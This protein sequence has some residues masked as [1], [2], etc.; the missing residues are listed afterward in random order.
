[1][2][3]IPFPSVPNVPGVPALLRSATVPTKGQLFNG[4]LGSVAEYFFGKNI[5]GVYDDKGNLAL[6][7]DSFLSLDYQNGSRI[8][9]AP[10]EKGTFSSYN[11]VANPY[12]CSVILAIGADKAARTKFLSKLE[13][14]GDSTKLYTVVTPERT[15]TSATLESYTYKRESTNG[16]TLIKAQLNFVQIR[17]GA[18]TTTTQTQDP[19]GAA[20]ESGG[21]IQPNEPTDDEIALAEEAE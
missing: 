13:E 18:L 5:W 8:S 16:V 3:L 4:L 12:D 15:Y 9:N 17:N 2:S 11:K 10:Q 1:M 19:S 7:A 6:E 14:I 21:Q 20:T